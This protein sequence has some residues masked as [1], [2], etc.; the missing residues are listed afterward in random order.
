M[1]DLTLQQLAQNIGFNLIDNEYLP[2]AG[3]Y[4]K[5]LSELGREFLRAITEASLRD[6]L[7]I[8]MKNDLREVVIRK[9][10][11]AG[12]YVIEMAQGHETALISTGFPMAE[13]KGPTVISEPKD[14][15]ILPGTNNG[16]IVMQVKRVP[17]AKTY[18]YQYTPDPLTPDSNW[19]TVYSTRSKKSIM[20]LPLGVKFG[21]RVGVIGTNEQVLYT[22]VLFRHVA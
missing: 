1:S 18:I 5:E 2:N 6:L 9:L 16:E 21:F 15:R 12:E 7:K 8:S 3:E 22:K 20:N 17:G 4:G 14:F 13:R 19:E 10:R 11:A